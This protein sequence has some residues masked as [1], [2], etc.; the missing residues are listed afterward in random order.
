MVPV[1]YR[2]AL[3]AKCQEE[4]WGSTLELARQFGVSEATMR[5]D[6]ET[7]LDGWREEYAD[8]TQRLQARELK[9]LDSLYQE[10]RRA[11]AGSLTDIT[12]TQVTMK[13]GEQTIVRRVKRSVGEA[14]YLRLAADISIH[15]TKILG[16][17]VLSGIEATRTTE[18]RNA[19]GSTTTITDR[20]RQVTEGITTATDEELL[21]IHRILDG[22]GEER[23]E[24]Q[25]K[26]KEPTPLF[27]PKKIPPLKVP[28]IY[29]GELE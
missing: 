20:V 23:N 28:E 6:I 21:A 8:T 10:A 3:V 26:P 5:R 15:K 7:I 11:W 19:D 17:G 27:D 25:S 12:E 18:T 4:G 9:R 14:A 13:G 29:P 2:R 16:L 22:G 24:S 1:E